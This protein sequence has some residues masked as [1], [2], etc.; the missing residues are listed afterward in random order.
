MRNVQ[1][2]YAELR[3]KFDRFVAGPASRADDRTVE[4]S[5]LPLRLC[6]YPPGEPRYLRDCPNC[7]LPA[8]KVNIV[9]GP[10]VYAGASISYQPDQYYPSA[11][12][13]GV[14]DRADFPCDW[15]YAARRYN[16]SGNDSFHYQTRVL[17]NLLAQPAFAGS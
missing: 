15:P 16:G 10:P 4:H 1:K 8:R 13:A 9:R 17:L 3:D 7:A 11:N 12:Y 2:A 5:L 6:K 14:P